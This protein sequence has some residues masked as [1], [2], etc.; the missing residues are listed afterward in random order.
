MLC[1]QSQAIESRCQSHARN[2]SYG[3]LP[4]TATHFRSA[5]LFVPPSIIKHACKQVFCARQLSLRDTTFLGRTALLVYVRKYLPLLLDIYTP[6][7]RDILLAPLRCNYIQ[8][9]VHLV[10]QYVISCLVAWLPYL[11]MISLDMSYVVPV[12]YS[13]SVVTV[14]HFPAHTFHN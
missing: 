4:F 2:H 8:S 5:L 6:L 9:F 13:R 12:A 1:S 14:T 7:P 3:S 11:S 10:L